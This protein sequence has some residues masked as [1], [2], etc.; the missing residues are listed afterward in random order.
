MLQ[1]IKTGSTLD[2]PLLKSSVL[3]QRHTYGEEHWS[4]KNSN[5][6]AKTPHALPSHWNLGLVPA[7]FLKRRL[8]EKALVK[9]GEGREK[10]LVL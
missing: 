8:G 10:L 3:T 7:C 9:L 6:E 5:P 2:V 4:G 1:I